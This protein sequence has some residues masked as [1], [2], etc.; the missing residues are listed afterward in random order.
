[1]EKILKS[2]ALPAL[3]ALLSFAFCV[4]SCVSEITDPEQLRETITTFHASFEQPVE[5]PGT[6]T[7][8][9]YDDGPQIR[10]HDDDK[11]SIFNHSTG[12]EIY[13]FMG[14]TGDTTGD[15]E[16]DGSNV[17]EG[18]PTDLIYAVYPQQ[19]SR[20]K[21]D[22]QGYFLE[23]DMP[24]YQNTENTDG[25]S[26]SQFDNTMV[27]VG[28]TENLSFRNVCG[29]L[30]I[31]MRGAEE[32]T[33]TDITLRGNNGE[34]ISGVAEVRIDE[35]GIPVCTMVDRNTEWDNPQEI[36]V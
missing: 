27:S 18:E 29:Y 36:K 3:A 24:R 26:F 17:P 22:D 31:K 2:A 13:K 1:M 32:M 14:D 16:K 15:F 7:Y 28:S 6:R 34:A 11:I 30:G 21:K 25:A 8:C 20:L 33:T 23:I 35:N 12:E 5:A 9:R 19:I 10:W 4:V